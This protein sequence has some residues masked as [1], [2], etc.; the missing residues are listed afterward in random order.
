[1]MKR[2]STPVEVRSW[3]E[4]DVLVFGEGLA[5]VEEEQQ[6]QRPADVEVVLGVEEHEL[7]AAQGLV[8]R[9]RS[10][11]GPTVRMFTPRICVSPPR[12]KRW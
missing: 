12:K 9:A 4:V 2:S 3:L 8:W 10:M 7:V 5:G 11:T 6:A 1:M